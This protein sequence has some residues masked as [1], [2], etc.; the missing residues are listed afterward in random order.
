[1]YTGLPTERDFLGWI[2]PLPTRVTSFAS[3][4]SPL[5]GV[6]WGLTF[7]SA[8][9]IGV[10]MYIA[11]LGEGLITDPDAEPFWPSLFESWRYCAGVMLG[12]FIV[13]NMQ[14]RTSQLPALR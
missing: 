2:A 5:E 7:L 6:V 4:L 1:M 13:P 10:C 3:F 9:A 14:R 12:E 11:S 8:F